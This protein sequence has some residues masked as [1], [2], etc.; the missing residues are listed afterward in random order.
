M[1]DTINKLSDVKIRAAKPRAKV[2]KLSDGNGLQLWIDPRGYRLWRF[3]YRFA[4]Q[5]KTLAIGAYPDVSLAVARDRRDEARSLLKAHQDPSSVRKVERATRHIA[6]A[7]TF[8]LVS[9]ELL[10]R[11]AE[12]RRAPATL[13]LNTWLLR[14]ACESL[15]D[16]PISEIT[17]VEVLAVLRGVEQRGRRASAHRMRAAIGQ[18]FRYAIATARAEN[19]PTVALRGALLDT[20]RKNRAAILHPAELGAFLRAA[21]GF[22][23]QPETKAALRLL[24]LL[25]TRPGELRRARWQEFSLLHAVWKV[26]A[27][28]DKMRRGFDVP[29]ARQACAMLEELCS[30][31]GSRDL[32]FPGARSPNRPL[33]ENT[34]NA[35][36]RR[37]GYTEEQVTAHGFRATA[38]TLLNESGLWSKEAI[39]RSLAHVERDSV[40]RAYNRAAYWD[41]R[42]RMMQWWAD[43]LDEL[44]KGLGPLSAATPFG[45]HAPGANVIKTALGGTK[46]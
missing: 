34:L 18:V 23:G 38:S 24:P 10:E 19:D 46:A 14:A 25:F 12:Q 20:T 27:Q 4:G 15:G 40:R 22:V 1:A 21:D 35:A 32:V 16:R 6:A 13:E 3:A 17:A 7:N 42:V 43:H 29:L 11:S 5:Q 33:S 2:H 37:M 39:E 36:M 8:R 44:K 45:T 28:N 9:D 30:I 26:P 31:S 41:E